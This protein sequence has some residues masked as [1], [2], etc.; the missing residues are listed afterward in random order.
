MKKILLFSAA[1]LL[2]GAAACLLFLQGKGCFSVMDRRTSP[3]GTIT[4]TAYDG[5]SGAFSLGGMW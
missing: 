2:V 3:D 5:V 1:A 4:A